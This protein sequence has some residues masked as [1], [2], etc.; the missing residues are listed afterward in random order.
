MAHD[1]V[2]GDL[3]QEPRMGAFELLG[4]LACLGVSAVAFIAL[5]GWFGIVLGNDILN[6]MPGGE[7]QIWVLSAA[8]LLIPA[9]GLVMLHWKPVS[10]A[11]RP[12][13][14]NS[15]AAAAGPVIW[16]L[17]CQAIFASFR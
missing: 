14:W 5:A 2:Q 4:K 13:C 16:L 3:A 10:R 1:V 6:G 9:V 11:G 8:M 12:V 17:G 7:L 15:P